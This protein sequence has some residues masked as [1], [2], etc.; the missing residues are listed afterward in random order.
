CGGS[1][2]SRLAK[3]GHVGVLSERAP[4]RTGPNPREDDD[5]IAPRAGM[6]R[7]TKV[8][9]LVEWCR[10]VPQTRHKQEVPCASGPSRDV[11]V[12]VGG[13]DGDGTRDLVNAI[14]RD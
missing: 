1:R 8:S 13:A 14:L 9:P 12:G 4:A 5:T 7:W 6:F 2:E 3:M 10:I 11:V